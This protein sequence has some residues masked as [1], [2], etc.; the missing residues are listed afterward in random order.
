MGRPPVVLIVPA[1]FQCP[2]KTL[3]VPSGGVC[4]LAYGF[5]RSSALS[6]YKSPCIASS[7][8]RVD[9]GCLS[10]C[11]R[12]L[13][14]LAFSHVLSSWVA[15]CC[16]MILTFPVPS[17]G[18]RGSGGGGSG[19]GHGLWDWRMLSASSEVVNLPMLVLLLIRNF[20]RYLLRCQKWSGG[21]IGSFLPGPKA[22]V[23][24]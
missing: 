16:C 13:R 17:L 24:Y 23:G 19:G 10:V 6:S 14:W 2:T 4:R 8:F 21:R 1:D 12:C 15:R 22:S 7:N 9:F 18:L 11:V 5:G 3:A 20:C